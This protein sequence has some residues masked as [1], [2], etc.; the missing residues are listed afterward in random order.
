MRSRFVTLLCLVLLGAALGGCSK[1]GPLWNEGA[2]ACHSDIP[3]R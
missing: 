2:K 3:A 1:C